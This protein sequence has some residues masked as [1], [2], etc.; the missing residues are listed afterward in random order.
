MAKIRN[1]EALAT[2]D[3]R[4]VALDV[5]EVGLQAIDTTQVIHNTV[6]LSGDILTISGNQISLEGVGR[7]IVAGIGKCAAQAAFELEQILGDRIT[8][9][10]LITVGPVVPLRRIKSVSG[11]HPFPSKEN[12]EASRMLL[13][14][15]S[16]LEEN[17]LVIFLVTGGGS[18]LLCLPTDNDVERESKILHAFMSAAAPIQDINVVRKHMSLVRG[19]FLAKA[20]YPARVVSLIFNDVPSA[21]DIGFIASGPTVKDMTTVQDAQAILDRYSI[22]ET[23]GLDRFD[24][25]ETPKEDMY[26]ERVTNV[27]VVSNETALAAMKEVAEQKGYSVQIVDVKSSGEARLIGSM[28]VDHLAAAT[29]HTILMWGGETT[30]TVRNKAGKGGRNQELALGALIAITDDMLVMTVATDGQ[31]NSDIG[32]ALCDR[33]TKEKVANFHLD[34]QKALDENQSYDFWKAAGDYL[35]TGETGSNVSDLIIAIKH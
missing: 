34:P 29:A 30:V 9:G 26:F 3:I 24:L 33:M 27:V 15:L 35:D 20:M 18:T 19:G 5:A 32:G 2:N 11:T 14:T 12:M 13:A 16:G 8:G 1:F 28:V 6:S 25:I 10:F 31:D 21:T 23:C 22:F 7:I 17:D 4:R